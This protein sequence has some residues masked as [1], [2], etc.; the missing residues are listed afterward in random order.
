MPAPQKP[1]PP[2]VFG[3]SAAE[4]ETSREANALRLDWADVATATSYDVLFGDADLRT[5]AAK[6]TFLR[7]LGPNQHHRTRLRAV[8]AEGASDWSDPA[9]FATRPDR[10]SPPM[11]PAP[12]TDRRH[13]AL[14]LA[15]REVN[16]VREYE[17]RVNGAMLPGTVNTP[18]LL[19]ALPGGS[20]LLPNERYEVCIRAR[21]DAVGGVSEW[22]DPGVFATRP[23]PPPAPQR[24]PYDLSGWGIVLKWSVP[25]TFSGWRA[26]FIRLTRRADGVVVTRLDGSAVAGGYKDHRLVDS[27]QRMASV[28]EYS[29]QTVVPAAATPA[30]IPE[31]GGENRSFVSEPLEAQYPI[32]IRSL[33][34]VRLLPAVR[35]RPVTGGAS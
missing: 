33:R 20:G 18:F 13:D 11:L 30:P 4:R 35:A 15:W 32:F 3:S 34:P 27:Q 14:T 5:G 19:R 8:N 9:T 6:G 16:G 25:D 17:L 1:N 12:A 2:D 24:T 21:D 22:S 7:G 31:D 26:A 29:L 10:P 28:K 23:P